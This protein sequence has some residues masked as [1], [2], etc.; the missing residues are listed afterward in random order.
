VA[1]EYGIV[2]R[3]FKLAATEW[4]WLR[5]SSFARVAAP[6]AGDAR[7]R[8][9]AEAKTDA[10][11]AILTTSAARPPETASQYIAVAFLLV[12]ETMM[13][14]G[15]V[16]SLTRAQVVPKQRYLHCRRPRTAMRV[17]CRSPRPR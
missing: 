14:Q 10:I 1:R 4:V 12:L 3:I 13:R 17:M 11:I 9:V 5:D 7:T 16:L 2:R 8:R 15:E 6:P